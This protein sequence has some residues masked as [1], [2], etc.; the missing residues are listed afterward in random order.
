MKQKINYISFIL[1]ILLITA[2][3]EKN[4]DIDIDEI[5]PMI[6]MNGLLQTDSTVQIYLSRTRH[7]LDNVQLSSLGGA[8]VEISGPDGNPVSLVYGKDQ[9]YRTDQIKIEAG[10]EYTVTA[11]ADGFNSVSA[12][13]TMPKKVNIRKIDTLSVRNEWGE[14]QI[15]FDI[16]IEDPPDETN[17]YMLSLKAR[18]PVKYIDIIERIDTLY[19]D[20]VKDTVILGYVYDTLEYFIPRIDNIYV[21]SEDLAVEQNDYFSNR[22]IFS[23]KLFD[24]KTYSFNGSFYDWFLWEAGDSAT[25]YISLQSVDEHYYKYI[26]SRADHY[27]AKNDPFAVPVVVHNNIE[28]GIGI[29]GGATANVDSLKIAPKRNPWDYYYID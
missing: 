29:L 26:D 28:N 24:G 22:I 4:V 19:V 27:Y 8:T 13:S 5:E 1:G 25:V 18:I 10:K 2:A 17:Y 9:L 3:C 23:D 11:S 7:I 12:V 14:K 15:S 21:E 16:L 6:V 20:P